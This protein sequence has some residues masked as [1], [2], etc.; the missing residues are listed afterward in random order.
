MYDHL[1]AWERPLVREQYVTEQGGNCFHC[2]ALLSGEPVDGVMALPLD[3]S[4]FP[5]GFL[6]HPVHLHHDHDTG[7]TLGA[8]H[9]RCNAVL[10]LYYGE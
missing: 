4:P 6:N 7:L 2:G 9:A 1:K 5:P 10:F 3:M 8:V